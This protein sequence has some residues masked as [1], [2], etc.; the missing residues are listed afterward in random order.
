MTLSEELQ[1]RGF[2]NQTTF[3]DIKILDGDSLTFY[4]GVDP[5]AKSMHIGQ[6]AMAMMIKHFIKAGH[7]PILLVGGAT[8]MIG[9]PDGKD[10]ER[11]LMS[12]DTIETNKAGIKNQYL[13]LFEGDSLDLVDNYDWFKGIGFLDFLRNVGKHVPMSQM[14]SREFVSTRLGE[15]GSG[16]SYAEFSYA[17][18]QGY[19]FLHLYREK[20]ATLQVCGSDQWGNC[21]A[22]VELIRRLEGAEAH[23]WSAPLIINKS[24]GKKFGKTEEGA[25]WLDPKLTS[26]FKFYQFWINADDEGVE[27]YLKIYT[28]LDKD[29]IDSIITDHRSDP[30]ARIA[31][32]TLAYEV[33]KIVHGEDRAE[34]VKSVSGVLFGNQKYDS[35]DSGAFEELESELPVLEMVNNEMSIVEVLVK[36]GLAGSNTEARRFLEENAVYVNGDQIPISKTHLEN[37]DL[38]HGYVVVRRGKNASVLVKS[39][40]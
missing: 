38:L 20:G 4:W 36:G 30:S 17:L 31:Q 37:S 13:Q 32:K 8:G 39:N 35:L 29:K 12:I 28:E 10:S 14:V 25:V 18:I 24:T 22:G 27:E 11:D 23:I 16:L 15:G 21:I 1:W 7:K 34:S 33:T 40:K 3:S 19:D 5:S 6:L 26:P 2:V 9:D